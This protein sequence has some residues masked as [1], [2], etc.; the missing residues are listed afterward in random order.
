MV[1]A[2]AGVEGVALLEV[3]HEEVGREGGEGEAPARLESL[4]QPGQ[5]GTVVAFGGGQPEAAL[6]E[7]HD[8][9][10]VTLHGQATG[11]APQEG[12]PGRGGAG[13]EGHELGGDVDAHHPH[14]A[15]GQGVGVAAGATAHVEQALARAQA[16]GVDEEGDLLVGAPGEG[17]AEIGR[18]QMGGDGLEPVRASA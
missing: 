1:H 17:V 9:V 7:G 14:P 2:G 3:A 18:A 16:E 12:G 4:C 15:S 13:G 6:A 8:S 10:E 5:D 11:I